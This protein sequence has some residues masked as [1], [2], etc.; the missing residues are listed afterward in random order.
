MMDSEAHLRAELE[1]L[2][3]LGLSLEQATAHV[4][5]AIKFVREA[6]AKERRAGMRIVAGTDSPLNGPPPGEVSA[7]RGKHIA[8]KSF[9]CS[10]D[11]GV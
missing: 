4:H 11:V 2:M 3:S 8:P 7:P 1:R 10:I 9:D 6:Q 5:G